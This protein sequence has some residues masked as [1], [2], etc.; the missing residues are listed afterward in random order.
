[1][2]KKIAV[3]LAVVMM[4]FLCIPM[5][6]AASETSSGEEAA[7]VIGQMKQQLE[8]VF[9]NI[10]QETASEVFSFLK[11]KIEEGNLATEEGISSAIEEGKEKFGVEI[12][13]ED[14]KKLV[15]A[16]EKLENMGFSAEYVIEKAENLYQEYGSDF[17]NHVD[18]VVTGAVKNAVSGAIS[19]FFENLTN[20]VKK[21]FTDLFS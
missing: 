19:S 12:S 3:I 2:K 11:E 4:V 1:M 9:A 5:A 10:D 13:K 7:D 16:M 21:F 15:D 20:S 8:E 6:A 14:A 17:V 18:E